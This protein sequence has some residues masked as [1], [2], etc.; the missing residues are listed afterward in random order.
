MKS[1]S[2]LNIVELAI[3]ILVMSTSGVLGKQ[4]DLPVVLIIWSRCLLGAMALFLIRFIFNN[5][6]HI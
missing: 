1:T 4:I 3:A 6:F 2:S 5:S